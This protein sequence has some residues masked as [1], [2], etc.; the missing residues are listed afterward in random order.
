MSTADNVLA[1]VDAELQSA[2]AAK[3][4]KVE[5]AIYALIVKEMQS[6]GDAPGG[7]WMDKRPLNGPGRIDAFSAGKYET[8]GAKDH[9]HIATVA[10]PRAWDPRG[11]A[12]PWARSAGTTTAPGARD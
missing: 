12:R 2:G 11:R 7:S 6:S 9:G 4:T 1:A 3:L 5:R 8:L 10:L